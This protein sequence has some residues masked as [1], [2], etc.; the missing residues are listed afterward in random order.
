[1]SYAMC[2][3]TLSNRSVRENARRADDMAFV[4]TVGLIVIA[5]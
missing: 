1:M 3:M 4:L 5:V 2:G